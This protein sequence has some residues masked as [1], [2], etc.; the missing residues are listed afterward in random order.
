L[1]ATSLT[2]GLAAGLATGLAAG[3]ATR[4]TNPGSSPAD[5]SKPTRVAL[6]SNSGPPGSAVVIPIYF[7]PAPGSEVSRLK[8]EI[9]FV[10]VNLKFDGLERGVAAKI[11][12]LDLTSDLQVS[13]NSKGVETSTVTVLASFSPSAVRTKGIPGGILGYLKL[14]IGEKATAAI[15]TLRTKAEGSLLGSNARIANLQSSDGL[16]EISWVDAPPNVTCFFFTH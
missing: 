1:L 15:I 12:N 2:A 8:L 14:R 6:A 13:K 10:S 5:P 9:N 7:T 3:Q 16:V 11:P 4:P